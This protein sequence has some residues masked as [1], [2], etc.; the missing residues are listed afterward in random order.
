MRCCMNPF[1]SHVMTGFTP[2]V[3][4]G[5]S[6]TRRNILVQDSL[7]GEFVQWMA[8]GSCVISWSSS[9]RTNLIHLITGEL[10]EWVSHDS[11][12]V[13]FVG[14]S[15]ERQDRGVPSYVEDP[16]TRNYYESNRPF[17]YA[18]TH[19]SDY[20]WCLMTTGSLPIITTIVTTI[21]VS[22]PLSLFRAAFPNRRSSRPPQS[23]A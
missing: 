21:D 23:I 17:F 4:Q 18:F 10:R 8:M 3:F 22:W 15:N 2:H 1:T 16:F 20:H 12:G 19:H 6:L 7:I 14:P 5:E 9:G 13:N 11:I